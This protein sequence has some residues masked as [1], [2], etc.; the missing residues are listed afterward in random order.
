MSGRPIPPLNGANT[1]PL[2]EHALGVLRKLRDVGPLPSY[3]L[4]P[5]V[6]NRLSREALAE[7]FWQ[8]NGTRCYRI[9]D[10][11]RE[12]LSHLREEKG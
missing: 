12:V 9:T 6:R 5:G 3:L 2:S 8:K 4:N 7:E 10:I 1:R 11:G